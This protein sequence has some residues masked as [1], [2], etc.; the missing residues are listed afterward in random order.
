MPVKQLV[1]RYGAD[2]AP[3]L[4][5]IERV[6]AAVVKANQDIESRFGAL[7]S[8]MQ[9]AGAAL[10]VGLTL[11][12]ALAGK[13]AV[14]ANLRFDSLRRGMEAV[15]GSGG[16]AAAEIE[17][18]REVAKLP[19]LGFEEAQRGSVA[20]QAAGYSAT[21]ARKHL[22]AFGNALATVGYG[23]EQLDMVQLALVQLANRTSGFG[24]EIRQLQNSV[25]MIRQMMIKAFGTADSEVISKMG[26]TGKQ[27]VDAIS[28][29]LGKLPKVTGGVRNSFENMSDSINRA[30]ANIGKAAEPAV[31]GFAEKVSALA[32]TI[33]KMDSRS[34][35]SIIRFGLLAAAAGPVIGAV[36]KLATTF[37]TMRMAT[38]MHTMALG[39][40]TA[41]QAANASAA[42][43]AALA[44]EANAAA[45]T[46]AATATQA[47]GAGAVAAAAKWAG[48]VGIAVM[49]TDALDATVGALVRSTTGWKDFNLSIIAAA[50]EGIRALDEWRRARDRA[51]GA[52]EGEQIAEDYVRR[53]DHSIRRRDEER[54]ARQTAEFAAASASKPTGILDEWVSK[55][56][57]AGRENW[58]SRVAAS[59]GEFAGDR[60]KAWV[61]YKNEQDKLAK[62]RADGQRINEREISAKET[63]LAK[64]RDIGEREQ[65]ETKKRNEEI[66]RQQQEAAMARYENARA[67][68]SAKVSA[69]AERAKMQGNPYKAALIE[70]RGAYEAEEAALEV[71]AAKGE[72]VISRKI[73]NW[74]KYAAAVKAATVE[75]VKSQRAETESQIEKS[76]AKIEAIKQAQDEERQAALSRVGFSSLRGMWQAGMTAG[77]KERYAVPDTRDRAGDVRSYSQLVE[78][79]KTLK[80]ILAAFN[81]RLGDLGEAVTY[82]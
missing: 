64:I 67:E 74:W 63:Y 33:S 54:F 23:K 22:M 15:M 10:S 41:A 40:N 53:G 51:R 6:N 70:A 60:A 28:E 77:A 38:D 65:A 4:A 39:R 49:V 72:A 9:S 32:E 44:N 82:A 24:Q 52:E 81:K 66:A 18:L 79:T 8:R 57:E 73:A 1:I 29:E 11:P 68:H 55:E 78:Q 19:G 13:A 25:P 35:N 7:S 43:V 5:G 3:A 17:K 21:E 62:L 45:H 26:I 2:I 14:D 80:Q 48:Y 59:K 76:R 37:A 31:V 58:A 61:D 20:L 36:A 42:N 30:L 16:A 12:L 46:A 75:S 47:A 71:A 56:T 27:F 69:A 34:V 50:N